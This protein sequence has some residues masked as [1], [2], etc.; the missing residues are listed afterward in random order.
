MMKTTR[1]KNN[2]VFSSLGEES[3]GVSLEDMS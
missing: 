1:G 2:P 3:R